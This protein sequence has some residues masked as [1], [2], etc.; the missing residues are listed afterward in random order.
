MKNLLLALL[1]TLFVNAMPLQ[2]AYAQ[3]D[4]AK[5]KEAC[6]ISYKD[7][8]KPELRETLKA[9]NGTVIELEGVQAKVFQ[10]RVEE[11][12]GQSAPFKANQVI[13][14]NPDGDEEGTTNIAFF[15][16]NC[17][18]AAIHLPQYVVNTLT[19]PFEKKK[20]ERVE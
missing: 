9:Q 4:D 12:V 2:A 13:I 17:L 16:D 1:T 11:L 10:D 8:I 15:V 20:G 19:S 18:K 6:S 7:V 5:I 14:V 3:A